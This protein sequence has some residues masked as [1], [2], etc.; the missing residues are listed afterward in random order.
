VPLLDQRSPGQVGDGA[1]PV[2][3]E[4][5]ERQVEHEAE[6]VP[7]QRPVGCEHEDLGPAAAAGQQPREQSDPGGTE[8]LVGQPRPHSPGDQRGGEQRG[9][10][11]GEAEA[12]PE[13]PPGQDQ[14]EEHGLQAGG[15]GPE[16]AQGSAERGQH[17]EHGYGLGVDA[18]LGELGE[19][20]TQHQD[21]EQAEQHRRRH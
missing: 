15:A 16:R 4:R 1:G 12:R 10:A 13:D 5:P 19:H 11:E 6:Q 20:H 9:A 18:A 2:D 8:H 17:A 3:R 14:D 21:Q 7:R